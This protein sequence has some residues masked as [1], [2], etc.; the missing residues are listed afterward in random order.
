MTSSS[1]S[2]VLIVG[3]GP[4]GLSL[5]ISLAQAGFTTTVVEQQSEATLAHPAPDGRE[6]ALT[7]PS[8]AT[9]QRLG[10]WAG[11]AP[12][13]VGTIREAQVHDGPL[14][15]R[16]ALQLGTQGTGLEALGFIVPNHALRRTAYAVAART[17]GVRIVTGA[18]VVRVATQSTHAELEYLPQTPA[19]AP[20]D[21]P[22]PSP[23][24]LQAPLLVAADSRSSATRRQLGIGARIGCHA[25]NHSPRH[26]F[27][28]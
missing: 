15:Q 23:Q 2:D 22:A 13:E 7:H 26:Q 9:L 8:V 25:A 18:Q 5:A 19:G 4:A 21:G 17:P 14:G 28:V 10:T 11:L 24:R 20:S 3:A 6:I 27:I 12:H 1:H 16:S